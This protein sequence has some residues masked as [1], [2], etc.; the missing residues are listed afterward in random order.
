MIRRVFTCFLVL[1]ILSTSILNIS[2]INIQANYGVFS[3]TVSADIVEQSTSLKNIKID[4]Y[5]STLD[6][7]DPSLGLKGYAHEYVFSIYTNEDGSFS[8]TKP[9][10]EFLVIIDIDSLPDGYGIEK[11]TYFYKRGES[12]DTFLLRPISDVSVKYNPVYDNYIEV[13]AVTSDGTTILV[14]YSINTSDDRLSL[15]SLS[16]EVYTLTG[17]V[18]SSVKNIDFSFEVPF[19][20]IACID[21]AIATQKI[22][23][24]DAMNLLIEK[25]RNAPDTTTLSQA[26]SAAQALSNSPATSGKISKE[27]SDAFRAV[28]AAPSYAS[29]RVYPSS[30]STPFRIHYESSGL[31]GTPAF[32]TAVYNHLVTTRNNL[33]VT[34]NF[35]EP[36]SDSASTYI[37]VYITSAEY[38][39]HAPAVSW[40][41]SNGTA[42]IVIYEISNLSQSLQLTLKGTISHEYFHCIQNTYRPIGNTPDWLDESFANW[43][44]ITVAGK[45]S[46]AASTVNRYLDYTYMS[47]DDNGSEA[48][49]TNGRHYGEV[50]F[51]LYLD[52][53]LGGYSTIRKVIE[54]FGNT[55]SIS[56]SNLY[57]IN[58]ITNALSSQNSNFATFFAACA[59]AN[60]TPQ[61]SYDAALTGY[62]GWRTAPYISN[63]YTTTSYPNSEGPYSVNYLAMHYQNFT[64]PTTGSYTI[65]FTV[66]FTNGVV[67][68]SRCKLLLTGRS[69]GNIIERTMSQSSN[70][71]TYSLTSQGSIYSKACIMPVNVGYST[72]LS[73]R[74]TASLE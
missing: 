60:Y 31:P 49:G 57:A 52:Q 29:E 45:D 35:S 39:T 32:V 58:A 53:Y 9:S 63:N 44:K 15:K 1:I 65:D 17:T 71:Y 61:T 55:S 66:N 74:L 67:G 26:I 5:S 8:F 68:N 12:T 50:L 38:S 19:N 42:Y 33:V 43:A 21:E 34:K 48:D 25:I 6:Q 62:N 37:D 41:S 51:P 73:Y 56:N 59:A 30:S 13:T 23:V 36:F 22:S 16:S 2:A 3:G 64:L 24:T 20:S 14:P 4:I 54:Y 28:T 46:L 7:Q 27:A 11:G 40:C 69:S 10:F 18:S 70:L 72:S 47:L